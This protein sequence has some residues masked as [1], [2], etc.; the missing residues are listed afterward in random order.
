MVNDLVFAT[1]FEGT[2][3]A[4]DAKTG[5]EVWQGALPAG[6]NTGVTVSGDTLIAP[7]GLPVA[8]GQTPEIVAFRL[9]GGE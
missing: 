3:H 4:L 6:T 9:P 2:V 5:G 1:T 7:A 8:E